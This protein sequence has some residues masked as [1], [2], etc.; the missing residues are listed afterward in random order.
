LGLDYLP[1]PVDDRILTPDDSLFDSGAIVWDQINSSSLTF[2]VAGELGIELTF[3]DFP[4][5]GIWTKPGGARFLCLEPWQGHM[6]PLGFRGELALKPGIV[7]IAPGAS[8]Q[9]SQTIR[10]VQHL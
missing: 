6:S 7:T 1:T 5:F 3:G 10:P 9:W 4:Q 8:R 2:G